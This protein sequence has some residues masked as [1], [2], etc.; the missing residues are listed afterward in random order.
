MDQDMAPEA[1]EEGE[2]GAEFKAQYVSFRD[3]LLLGR[4]KRAGIEPVDV[5][6]TVLIGDK[7]PITVSLKGDVPAI[8]L[9]ERTLERLRKPFRNCLILKL[10]GRSIGFNMLRDR[11]RKLW[12]ISQ[13]TYEVT[14][15]DEGYYMVKFE[16]EEDCKFV[17][18]EGPWM[19][20]GHYL[21]V[22][23]WRPNFR[24]AIDKIQSTAVWVQLPGCPVEFYDEEVLMAA[25]ELLGK[26]LKVD[27]VTLSR[28]RG[29]FAKV[30]VEVDLDKPLIPKIEIHGVEQ[31]VR[32]E[33][34]NM[35]CFAC[36]RSGHR[37]DVCP[38]VARPPP[39]TE[40][41]VDGC[42]EPRVV[43]SNVQKVNAEP[44]VFGQWMAPAKRRP[45]RRNSRPRGDKGVAANSGYPNG[46]R[47][48]IL[49]EDND[50]GDN[51]PRIGDNVQAA[52]VEKEVLSPRSLDAVGTTTLKAG[53][54][55][56][57]RGVRPVNGGLHNVGPRA[58]VVVQPKS[59]SDA[60]RQPFKV[61]DYN[62]DFPVV[63]GGGS[64]SRTQPNSV[65]MQRQAGAH[66]TPMQVDSSS[67]GVDP[68]RVMKTISGGISKENREV[69]GLAKDGVGVSKGG[70]PHV[71]LSASQ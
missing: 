21:T 57:Q 20:L 41:N 45:Q 56:A 51:A 10:L 55:Q 1:L 59:K 37:R 29:S 30:C 8:R 16:E 68:A 4:S 13:D 39:A 28:K 63:H 49:Q 5:E 46:S 47:F 54:M 22:R 44:E 36:G 2:V 58:K 53:A 19:V 69:L 15:L 23:R 65:P 27:D 48:H 7:E 33:G 64:P 71:S 62:A 67:Q 25:G 12:N 66:S 61:V 50:Q 17:L 18:E 14:D 43:E 70:V 24:P 32:Y 9:S 60:K 11:L 40:K 42:P 38:Y 3:T 52:V 6:A 26:P 34:L 35:I 31:V